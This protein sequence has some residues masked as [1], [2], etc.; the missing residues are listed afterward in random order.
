[1]KI[2]IYRI[3][4]VKLFRNVIKSTTFKSI[5]QKKIEKNFNNLFLECLEEKL[6]TESL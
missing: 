5:M 6:S 1:M 4:F 3:K 2:D